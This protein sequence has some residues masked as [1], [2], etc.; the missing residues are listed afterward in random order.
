MRR[1]LAF[2]PRYAGCDWVFTLDGKGAINGVSK[3]KA[4]L[5]AAAGVSGWTLHDLRRTARTLMSRG[6][7]SAEHSERVLGHVIGGVEGVYDK[8]DYL[9]EKR[10]A[11]DKLAREVECILFPPPKVKPEPGA[12]VLPMRRRR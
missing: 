11:L 10:D 4:A 12:K 7:A 3:G 8:H 2:L 1:L 6:G 9:P 5:D